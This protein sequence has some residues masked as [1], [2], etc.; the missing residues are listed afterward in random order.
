MYHLRRHRTMYYLYFA[1]KQLSEGMWKQ[2]AEKE[3]AKQIEMLYTSD[4]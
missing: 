2:Q 3:I 1:D 4:I